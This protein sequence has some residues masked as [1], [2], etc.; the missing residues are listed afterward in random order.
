MSEQHMHLVIDVYPDVCIADMVATLKSVSARHWFQHGKKEKRGQ[1]K[2]K[3]W[4]RNY[5]VRSCGTVDDADILEY[6]E[7]MPVSRI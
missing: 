3:L 5:L 7:R 2:G 6:V 4:Y 1:P